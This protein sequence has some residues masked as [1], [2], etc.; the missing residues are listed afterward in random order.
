M[1]YFRD[2]K[3]LWKQRIMLVLQ[4]EDDS[5]R[6]SIGSESAIRKAQ[7]GD[8]SDLLL[9]SIKPYGFSIIQ[10]DRDI[11][12]EWISVLDNMDQAHKLMTD[13]L[14]RTD[15][16]LRKT[17]VNKLEE[18][19]KSVLS[20]KIKAGDP[21]CQYVATK[22]WNE[23]WMV[24][25]K[26]GEAYDTFS[27][28]ARNLIR[29]F[30]S[31]TETLPDCN[32]KLY[33]DNPVFRWTAPQL[34]CDS[35][36]P[37]YTANVE[38]SIT[39]EWSLLPLKRLYADHCEDT[40]K[41]IVECKECG[42][43]F[44]ADSLKHKYCSV[45]CKNKAIDRNKRNRL[46]DPNLARQNTLCR[47]AYQYWFRTIDRA[48]KSG[49]YS[50]VQIVEIQ[51]AMVGFRKSKNALAKKCRENEITTNELQNALVKTYDILDE[52]LESMQNS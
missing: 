35:I 45:Q 15:G 44:V 40:G 4:L 9:H 34:D 49:R 19:I 10:F 12:N 38:K 28:L 1:D 47:D 23:Y 52:I 43:V 42:A 36:Y 33:R 30:S 20:R 37:Q 51:E 21:F 32:R 5:E 41:V 22:L 31:G 3:K 18:K 29:P 46:S 50:E 24:R 14:V 26:K 25:G 13:T 48:K 7:K 17:D 11:K 2:C 27:Q 39:I 8:T 6:I 16:I